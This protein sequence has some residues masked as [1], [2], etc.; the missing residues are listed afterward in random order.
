MHAKFC[1]EDALEFVRRIDVNKKGN[2]DWAP[3]L[4]YFHKIVLLGVLDAMAKHNCPLDED[5]VCEIAKELAE[6]SYCIILFVD[7][8]VGDTL[9]PRLHP[10]PLDLNRQ[11]SHS[12][13]A[14]IH[15]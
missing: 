4:N 14:L 13:L 9:T 15:P 5:G 3:H 12:P 8:H 2:P 10:T 7:L 1:R 6:V 11:L